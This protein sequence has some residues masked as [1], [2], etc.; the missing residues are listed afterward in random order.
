MSGRFYADCAEKML[1]E[2][3][4]DDGVAKKLWEVSEELTGLSSAANSK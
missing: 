2:R 3:A 1:I 4:R